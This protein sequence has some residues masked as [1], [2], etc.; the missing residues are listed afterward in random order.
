MANDPSAEQTPDFDTT[1]AELE[2]LVS[3]ME[4]GDLSLEESLAAFERGV[5]LSRDAQMALTRAE[6]KVQLLLDEAGATGPLP[7]AGSADEDG[8]DAS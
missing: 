7:G 2:S 4:R 3:A 8:D 5:R 1:L 6:Q